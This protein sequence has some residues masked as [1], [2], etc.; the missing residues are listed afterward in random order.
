[1]TDFSLR[2]VSTLEVA[3]HVRP[4]RGHS[5]KVV[6]GRTRVGTW[7]PPGEVC[8]LGIC[9][10]REHTAVLIRAT[11]DPQRPVRA[12]ALG[13]WLRPFPRAPRNPGG[14]RAI[15]ARDPRARRGTGVVVQPGQEIDSVLVVGVLGLDVARQAQVD[16]A[17]KGA[18]PLLAVGF[19]RR[20]RLRLLTRVTPDTDEE[21]PGGGAGEL[22]LRVLVRLGE[23]ELTAGEGAPDDGPADGVARLEEP[24]GGAMQPLAG[25]RADVREL[26]LVGELLEFGVR[27]TP[28]RGGLA[29]PSPAAVR[30]GP[31]APLLRACAPSRGRTP[32]SRP[33]RRPA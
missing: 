24:A 12:I 17:L 3:G 9:C 11:S 30:G 23:G 4:R 31:V 19:R 28:P 26:A 13:P 1:M 33:P 8:S 22:R 15:R 20:A 32:A 5:A 2:Q 18:R 27:V 7:G 10:L 25:Q 16:E 6:P 14:T 21:R 29:S